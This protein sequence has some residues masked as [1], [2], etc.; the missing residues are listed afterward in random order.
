MLFVGVGW[1]VWVSLVVVDVLFELGRMVVSLMV[2]M[3]SSVG[4]GPCGRQFSGRLLEDGWIMVAMRRCRMW[5]MMLVAAVGWRL[6]VVLLVVTCMSVR[7]GLVSTVGWLSLLDVV[8]V[9]GV[10]DC[11]GRIMV[12]KYI[13]M[14]V[15]DRRR[16]D[17][18]VRAGCTS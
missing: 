5:C 4:G 9:V 8:G 6:W 18:L 1:H 13:F 3:M 10:V 7:G 12:G 16:R 14:V 15:W 11:V 17:L 2:V